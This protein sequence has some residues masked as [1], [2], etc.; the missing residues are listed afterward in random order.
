MR[1]LARSPLSVLLQVSY[2]LARLGELGPRLRSNLMARKALVEQLVE[3][4]GNKVPESARAHTYSSV[5]RYTGST[6]TFF[7][8]GGC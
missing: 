4:F 7:Y 6:F 3:T 5:S 2:A 1:V 8:N